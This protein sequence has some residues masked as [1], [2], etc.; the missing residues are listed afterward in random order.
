M[1][2]H[3]ITQSLVGTGYLSKQFKDAND[4]GKA[5][6]TQSSSSDR[7]NQ[8]RVT[9]SREGQEQTS[10]ADSSQSTRGI[11][12]VK[13]D[14]S[15]QLDRQ[16]IQELQKL[17]RRDAEVR[18]HEQAHLS[19]AGPYARGGASFTYERG[20]D[21]N[22][23]AIGGEVG[24]D[25]GKEATPE[26]TLVKMQIIKRAALAPASPSAADRRIASQAS[27][28][29]AQARQEL[30]V[31]TQEGLSQAGSAGKP[32]DDE[33]QRSPRTDSGEQ[34]EPSYSGATI[35]SVIA[36]YNKVAAS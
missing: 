30:L 16:E 26:A 14:T 6:E 23:Y 4:T 7:S 2:A 31:K 22:S 13:E 3:S 35:T 36:A 27:I 21:G 9:L 32:E 1:E 19:A 24:V 17:K 15:L 18:A 20:P 34:S 25:V 33:S 29:E 10:R 12:A 5:T 11:E 8:D 28:R